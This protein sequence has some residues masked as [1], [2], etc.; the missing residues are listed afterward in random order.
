MKKQNKSLIS[1]LLITFMVF[2]VI[3]TFNIS[4]SAI[5]TM[6]NSDPVDNQEPEL[7]TSQFAPRTIRVAVYYSSN[8]SM[9]SYGT[10]ACSNDLTD[11]LA[12]LNNGEYQVTLLTTED[13]SNHELQTAYYDI[14]IMADNLPQM[15]ISNYVKEFWLGGGGLLSF[16][17]AINFLCYYGILPPESI[18]NNGSTSLWSYKSGENEI[19]QR[20][21]ISKEYLVGDTFT[22]FGTWGTFDWTALQGT[23]IASDLVRI[24]TRTAD[25]NDVTVLGFDPSNGGGRIVQMPWSVGDIP[26]IMYDLVIDAVDWACPRPKA[27]IV[28]DLSHLPYGGVDSWDDDYTVN[29][30]WYST[31]RNNLVNRSYT[32][33]KL[34]PSASG[35]LTSSNLAPYDLLIIL[36]PRFNFTSTEVT[37]VSSWIQNGG[38]LL[39]YGE[40]PTVYGTVSILKNINYLLSPVDLLMNLTASGPPA[41]TGYSLKH[42]TIEECSNLYF[43]NPGL[44]NYSG[45][46]YPIWGYN[47]YNIT[48]AAQEY[49]NG[50]I[51][52]SS[53]INICG[54][55][56]GYNDN[57]KYGINAVN[58]LTATQAKAIALITRYS[59]DDP[60]D[61]AYR[62]PVARALNDLGIKFYLTSTCSYFNLSLVSN[63]F[64]LVVVDQTFGAGSIG[65]IDDYAT[66]IIN[67]M[68]NGGHLIIWSYRQLFESP[69]WDYL[70]YTTESL[71]Y[72]SPQEV[73]IWDSGHR[74]FNTPAH[75]GANNIT[76]SLD[77]YGYSFVNVTLYNN[78]TGIAGLTE[79]PSV[80]TNAIILGANG[81]AITNTFALTEYYDDTDDSTYPD[82]LE[83]WEN[84]IAYMTYQSLSV[85]IL[86]P[87]TDDNFDANAPSFSITT[88]GIIID[89]TYYTLNDAGHYPITSTSGTINQGAWDALSDGTVSLKVYVEDTAGNSIY[90]EVNIEKDTQD[91]I[92]EILSPTSGQAFNNTAPEFIVN[93]TDPNLDTIWYTINDSVITYPV[94]GLS[95]TINQTGWDALSDG[96]VTLTFYAGD[97]AGNTAMESIIVQKDTQDP[98]ITINSPTSGDDFGSTPPSFDITVIDLNLDTIWYTINDSVIT[99]PVTGLSGTINQ[100]GWDALSDGN[101]ELKFYAR[102]L[103]GNTAT[104]AVIVQ[105]DTQGPVITINSPASGDEFG[106]TPPSF[107][108]SVTDPNLDT[109]WY[110]LN[111]NITIL[112]NILVWTIPQE[113]WDILPE[114]SATIT[115]FANDTLGHT[116]SQSLNLT[117]NIPS[118]GIGLDYFMMSVLITLFSSMAIIIVIT[119]MYRKKQLI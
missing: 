39:I 18:G 20:H 3:S 100:T 70:G 91:P 52:L 22:P 15:N 97:L 38:S 26:S 16:D 102:D 101:I 69:L 114:G 23:S 31:F 49:G 105:K 51:I 59:S 93:I 5:Q 56:I 94:T 78:A 104:K 41:V 111:S 117:K 80:D 40:T 48:V 88:G 76:T 113:A 14:F 62:G 116:S 17:S 42:P 64:D 9:P 34:Y 1:I 106:S 11:T 25:S 65:F 24:A 74:I 27:R 61:N 103:A 13:I 46:A 63:D 29:P 68:D 43:F 107:N 60:N 118:R 108:I 87:Q 50:R 7:K 37:D 83:I 90:D 12:A 28:F 99:Y 47:Q 73:F 54:D 119:K 84:E 86:D 72:G 53:D 85:N 36:L 82:A 2:T 71:G 4:P 19:Y 6:I 21:P 75:Y 77:I 98:V 30:D 8:I 92:I 67:Y 10:G 115:V 35:N 81:R 95:G 112:G 79:T 89:E 55:A 66:E 32:F 57:L 33:D 109:I 96:N 110:T 58:W 45:D 44:I